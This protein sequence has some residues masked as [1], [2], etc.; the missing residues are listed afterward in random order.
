MFIG[1]FG[2][3]KFT[4]LFLLVYYTF[5]FYKKSF[6]RTVRLKLGN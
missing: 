1:S 2:R 6:I 3:L 5:F 4:L